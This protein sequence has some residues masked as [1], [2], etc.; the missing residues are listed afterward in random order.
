MTENLEERKEAMLET[1]EI[2]SFCSSGV[3]ELLP[4]WHRGEWSAAVLYWALPGCT[5]SE[6][7][8]CS[9]LENVSSL[10]ST[11]GE[12]VR[13]RRLHLPQRVLSHDIFFRNSELPGSQTEFLKP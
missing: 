7:V 1:T 4:P 11:G 8:L 3:K 13:P 12:N 5:D 2:Q 6:P 10:R 9:S